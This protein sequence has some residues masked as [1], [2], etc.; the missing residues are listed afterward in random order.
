MR[1]NIWIQIL[2]RVDSPYWNLQ[3]TNIRD[4]DLSKGSYTHPK[5]P[6]SGPTLWTVVIQDLLIVFP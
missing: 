1:L 2:L 6:F 5:L 3:P 4:A